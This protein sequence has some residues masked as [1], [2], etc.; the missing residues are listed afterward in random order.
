M[1]DYGQKEEYMFY[2]ESRIDEPMILYFKVYYWP[3]VFLCGTM[4]LYLSSNLLVAVAVSALLMAVFRRLWT[5]E[6]NG[7]PTTYNHWFITATHKF[8]L[9][10]RSSIAP[11]IAAIQDHEKFYR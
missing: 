8:P 2:L 4:S 3:Y 11:S 5:D 7:N 6:E 9:W 1:I 10:L